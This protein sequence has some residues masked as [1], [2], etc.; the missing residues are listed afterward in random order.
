M[1]DIN[2]IYKC[3]IYCNVVEIKSSSGNLVCCNKNMILLNENS[4]DVSIENHVLI[5]KRFDKNMIKI[6][7]RAYCNLYGLWKNE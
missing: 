2:Q 4:I 6:K 1:T 5:I 7:V 3:N